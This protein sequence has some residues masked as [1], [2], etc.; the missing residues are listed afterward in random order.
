MF[1]GRKEFLTMVDGWGIVIYFP[2]EENRWPQ[3]GAEAEAEAAITKP[4][5]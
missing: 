3:A 4:K 2:G 5:I 1:A